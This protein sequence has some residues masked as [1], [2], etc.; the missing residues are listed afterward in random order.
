MGLKIDIN[1]TVCGLLRWKWLRGVP[2]NLQKVG[3]FLGNLLVT[4]ADPQ[5]GKIDLKLQTIGFY[6]DT[7]EETDLED[8]ENRL[9]NWAGIP[10]A[11]AVT[12]MNG[13]VPPAAEPA[14]RDLPAIEKRF[15]RWGKMGPRF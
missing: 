14:K 8:I 6:V 4:K 7:V 1:A 12:C 5:K 15:A 13:E 3:G 2:R 11:P 9:L 10:G